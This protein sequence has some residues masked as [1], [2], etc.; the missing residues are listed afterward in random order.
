LIKRQNVDDL[1][2]VFCNEVETCQ[3][4]F[5]ECVVASNIWKEIGSVLDLKFKISNLSDITSL[6][7]ERKKNTLFNMIFAAILRTIWI[8]R[9]DQVFNRSQW[10]GL[11]GLW[12]QVAYSCAQ[13]K[14]L[15]KEKERGKLNLF[16]S[17]LEMLARLPPLLSWPEPG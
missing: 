7:N 15:L 4:L 8:T 9:N 5:F 17:K 3:H 16:L 2:C 14:I 13:W 10:F 12:R 1:T 6:W 11:Q